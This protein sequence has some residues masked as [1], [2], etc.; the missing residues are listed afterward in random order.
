M[1]TALMLLSVC[2]VAGCNA[3]LEEIWPTKT[4]SFSK[5]G[6]ELDVRTQYDPVEGGWFTRVYDPRGRLEQTDRSLVLDLVENQVGPEVCDGKPLEF[7]P[8]EIWNARTGWSNN[9]AKGFSHY[10]KTHGEWQIVAT[11]T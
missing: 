9:P 10:M 7:T 1:R 5:E 6:R 11:C 4:L 3:P 8:G 2:A